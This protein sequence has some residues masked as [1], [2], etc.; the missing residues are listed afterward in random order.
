MRE[1][2]IVSEVAHSFQM[3]RIP[4]TNHGI[5]DE[6]ALKDKLEHYSKLGKR[7][8]CS[9]NAASNI[10][11]ILTDVDTIST[12]VHSYSAYVFWDYATAAPYVKI[13]MN[14]SATAYK[15]AIFISTHK[16][17]GGP[18]TP[19]KKGTERCETDASH[20]LL[21]RYPH[22]Q[23]EALQST[24]AES[25][26]RW[27]RELRHSHLPR[28]QLRYRDAR[29]GRHTR[30]N[31]LCPSRP[32]LSTEGLARSRLHR[33]ARRRISQTIRSTLPKARDLVSSRLAHCATPA[34]LLLHYLRAGH[35]E[36]S[37]SQFRM[38]PSQRSI[39]H[40]SSI[41][42]RLCGTLRSGSAQCQRCENRYLLHVHDGGYVVSERRDSSRRAMFVF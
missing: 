10:T 27:H 3:V 42:L 18:G 32:G 1:G 4:T 33:S 24:S 14:P 30:Y 21:S 13:D 28:V 15:D 6:A 8:I 12:L 5:L 37:P 39:R 36:I 17:I 16:F 38:S 41:G 35:L 29:R 40:S 31:R 9:L 23:E 2:N 11:G 25:M 19:G 34:D 26:R 20:V 22:R 7:I